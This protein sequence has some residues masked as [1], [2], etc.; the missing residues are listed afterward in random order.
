MGKG[1]SQ[2]NNA[3]A[4]DPVMPCSD[5]VIS[6]VLGCSG[7]LLF[8]FQLS[9]QTASLH[10]IETSH[11]TS[12]SKGYHHNHAQYTDVVDSYMAA[13]KTGNGG[14]D[15]ELVIITGHSAGRRISSHFSHYGISF[16][17]RPE[18]TSLYTFGALR[19]LIDNGGCDLS[20][21]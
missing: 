3:S 6:L 9:C 17:P 10:C 5:V 16:E 2:G 15:C 4:V 14:E 19:A 1:A 20:P 21:R 7:Q 13:C 12:T 8:V 18:C 11:Y